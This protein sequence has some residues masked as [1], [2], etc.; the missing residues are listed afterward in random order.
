MIALPKG[1]LLTD[2]EG[3][4]TARL[5]ASRP[6]RKE[7]RDWFD[8]LAGS[9]PRHVLSHDRLEDG[10]SGFEICYEPQPRDAVPLATT[11]A[12]W[13]TDPQASVPAILGLGRFVFEVA[14][15]MGR[16]GFGDVLVAPAMIRLIPG[17]LE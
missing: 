7:M 11:I 16:R 6:A 8:G 9:R 10:R 12:G 5:R 3:T 4:M 2:A 13:R 15:E 1:Q 14:G 17:A